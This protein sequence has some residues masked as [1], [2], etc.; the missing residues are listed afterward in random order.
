MVINREKSVILHT[1]IA[2]QDSAKELGEEYL[3]MSLCDSEG[4]EQQG[5]FQNR[6]SVRG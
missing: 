3:E 6:A 1:P 2:L 4:A 5:W